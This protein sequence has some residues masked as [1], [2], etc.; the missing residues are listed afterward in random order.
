VMV[1]KLPELKVTVGL[2]VIRL[3]GVG[4]FQRLPYFSPAGGA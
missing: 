2:G 1:P 3:A 4:K